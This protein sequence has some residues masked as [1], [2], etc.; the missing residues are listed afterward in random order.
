MKVGGGCGRWD[1]EVGVGRWELGD[2]KW[3]YIE[4]CLHAGILHKLIC[5]AVKTDPFQSK[6]VGF[7]FGGLSLIVTCRG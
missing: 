4:Y 3:R 2:G 7:Y 1:L 6:R 5:D